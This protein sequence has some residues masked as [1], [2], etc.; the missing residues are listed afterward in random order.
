MSDDIVIAAS[1]LILSSSMQRTFC[2]LRRPMKVT[3]QKWRFLPPIGHS[4]T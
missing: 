4:P 1:D 3:A 2:Y